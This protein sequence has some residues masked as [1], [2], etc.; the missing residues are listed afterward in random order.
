MP[1]SVR[2]LIASVIAGLCAVA[3]SWAADT[4]VTFPSGNK[5]LHGVVYK[6]E[7][8]GPFPAV[9]YNHGSAGGMPRVK[10]TLGYFGAAVW[11]DDVFS[12]LN[13]TCGVS[14]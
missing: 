4:T 8:P 12:F 9:L 2:Q 1:R 10:V 5:R 3:P 6:P 14:N 7:G 11:A 13:G